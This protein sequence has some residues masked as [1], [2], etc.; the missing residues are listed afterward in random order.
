MLT[1]KILREANRKRLPKFRNAKGELTHTVD[2]GTDWAL[3]KWANAV[4]GELGEAANIIKKIERGDFTLEQA[5][6]DLEKELADVITYM[7][8]LAC[9]AG[10]NL[11]KAVRLKFNEVSQRCGADVF[12]THEGMIQTTNPS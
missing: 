2:N 3:S 7:D 6:G 12:I 10:V 1:F 8:I 4:L 5:R 11:A 9:A